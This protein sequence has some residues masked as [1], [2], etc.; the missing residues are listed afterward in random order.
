M[1]RKK[2]TTLTDI[3]LRLM[4]IL[5]DKGNA[6]VAEVAQA[7]KARPPLAYTTVLTVLRI[8]E[9]KG[10]L[11]HE[12]QGRAFRYEPAVDRETVRRKELKHVLKRFFENSP[13]LLVLNVL[14]QEKIDLEELKRLKRSIQENK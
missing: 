10:Y 6:T 5:W 12:E 7:L 14:E 9:K 8:L 13:Q 2:S 4:D 3:E 11:R 1:P